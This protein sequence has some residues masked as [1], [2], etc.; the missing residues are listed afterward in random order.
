MSSTWRHLP[1]TAR[2]VAVTASD[3][4]AAAQEQDRDGL[5]AAVDPLAAAEGSGLVLGT[6][7]RML[8]EETHPDGLGGDDVRGIIERCTRAAAVWE[9]AVDP[10]VLLVLL[11][12]A[13]GV[14]DPDEQAP[15]PAPES[16][17]RHA[18]LLVAHLLASTSSPLATY[19]AAAFAEIERTESQ[20]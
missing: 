3:A 10:H 1:T 15:R 14:H 7:V 2:A 18:A 12:G 11:A 13:L 17:A 4:V 16:L 9:P 20:D 8:L 5:Q 19:L 6:V